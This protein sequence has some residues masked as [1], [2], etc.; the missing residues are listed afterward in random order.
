M[1]AGVKFP[2]LAPSVQASVNTIDPL[3]AKD[4]PWY[5]GSNAAM[6]IGNSGTVAANNNVGN[7]TLG[8]ALDAVYGPSNNGCPGIW[9]YLPSTALAAPN[10]VAGW[11]WAVM[12]STTVGTVYGI[13]F[14][15]GGA[16][17][18]GTASAAAAGILSPSYPPGITLNQV[19]G[20][21]AFIQQVTSPGS[22]ATNPSGPPVNALLVPY[23][24]DPPPPSMV[25]AANIATGTGSGYTGV[26][27]EQAAVSYQM[28]GGAV[29]PAGSLVFEGITSNNNSAGA[30]T[31]KA[32]MGSNANLTSSSPATVVS[33]APT[34]AVSTVLT[35]TYAMFDGH[36]PGT[37]SGTTNAGKFVTAG[38]APTFFTLDE[39]GGAAGTTPF[40][41][42]FTVQVAVATDWTILQGHLITGNQL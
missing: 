4:S 34:T 30:K 36:T 37:P 2:Q 21:Q 3:C 6:M 26:T 41:A 33:S 29:G 15:P 9:L 42:G 38:S 22:S 7:I 10:N 12:T 16:A 27:T 11:Y 31:T 8:T 17:P 1:T 32:K 28:Q 35:R 13:G 39:S 18:D 23:F 20:G 14:S 5:L 40:Y 25:V 24:P 19:A